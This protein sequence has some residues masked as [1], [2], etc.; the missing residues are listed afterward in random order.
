[1][2]AAAQGGR[3]RVRLHRWVTAD[4]CI[5]LHGHMPTSFLA[6]PVWIVQD[7]D[8]GKTWQRYEHHRGMPGEVM[9]PGFA[10]PVCK[11]WD[12]MHS[13]AVVSMCVT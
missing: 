7:I 5:L 11:H 8:L 6:F 1:M 12:P 3:Q 13:A 10:I 2:G 9:F 4:T